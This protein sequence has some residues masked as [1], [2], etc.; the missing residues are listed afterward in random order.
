[1][2]A[3]G[4]DDAERVLSV[5]LPGAGWLGQGPV[6]VRLQSVPKLQTVED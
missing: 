3:N 6:H 4:E 5:Y 2:L 1:M